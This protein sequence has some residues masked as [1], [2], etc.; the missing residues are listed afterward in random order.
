MWMRRRIE[1]N[2]LV[3]SGLVQLLGNDSKEL[4]CQVD[5]QGSEISEEGRVV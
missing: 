1:D 5:I 4:M 2:L 3:R